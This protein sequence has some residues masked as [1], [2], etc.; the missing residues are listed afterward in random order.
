MIK[1]NKA[2]DWYFNEV[3]CMFKTAEEISEIIQKVNSKRLIKILFSEIKEFRECKNHSGKE[4]GYWKTLYNMNLHLRSIIILK[5]YEDYRKHIYQFE[6]ND[7]DNF[8]QVYYIR[9]NF[10]D[11]LYFQDI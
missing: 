2:E 9:L 7:Y 6:F 10:L 11:K 1:I 5:D 3:T 4:F 8:S